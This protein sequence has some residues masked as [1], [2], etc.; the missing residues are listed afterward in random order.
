LS[1]L[2]A[3]ELQEVARTALPDA[4]DWSIFDRL[5]FKKLSAHRVTRGRPIA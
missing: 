3:T 1:Q 5:D 2:N 4:I